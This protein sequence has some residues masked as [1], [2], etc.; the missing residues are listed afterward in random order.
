MNHVAA[1]HIANRADGR[2]QHFKS[3]TPACRPHYA[4]SGSRLRRPA[5]ISIA[6]GT[7]LAASSTSRIR[8]RWNFVRP[9]VAGPSCAPPQRLFG[10]N[11]QFDRT[12]SHSN[13]TK[14]HACVT[15]N[16]NEAER[17]GRQYPSTAAGLTR[18]L[19]RHRFA[20]KRILMR[21]LARHEPA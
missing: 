19:A 4:N 12:A 1:R 15:T 16:R 20:N 14:S 7:G 17:R 2:W 21:A 18:T 8:L 10:G 3:R 13:C 5:K 6:T 11:A 9:T